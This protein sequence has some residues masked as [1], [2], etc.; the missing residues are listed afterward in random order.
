MV[1]E[2]SEGGWTSDEMNV[3]EVELTVKAAINRTTE[4]KQNAVSEAHAAVK[5][6]HPDVAAKAGEI[7]KEI[8]ADTN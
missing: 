2:T 5:R 6:A 8:N 7:T 4:T 1:S 3:T